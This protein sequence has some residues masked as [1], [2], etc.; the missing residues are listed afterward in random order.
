[1]INGLEDLYEQMTEVR[2]PDWLLMHLSGM[3]GF[4]YIRNSHAPA[5]RMVFWGM[6]IAKYQFAELADIVGFEWRIG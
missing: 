3:L 6:Q 1:M 4:V 2:P 5:P